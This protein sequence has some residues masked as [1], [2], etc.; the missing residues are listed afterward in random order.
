MPKINRMTPRDCRFYGRHRGFHTAVGTVRVCAVNCILWSNLGNCN[1]NPL[2][3]AA[4]ITINLL[5]LLR[6]VHGYCSNSNHCHRRNYP[7]LHTHFA[8]GWLLVLLL[9]WLGLRA[10]ARTRWRRAVSFVNVFLLWPRCRLTRTWLAEH[11]RFA[12]AAV[13]YWLAFGQLVG[14]EVTKPELESEAD[15][16]CGAV[17]QLLI[18]KLWNCQHFY[19]YYNYVIYKRKTKENN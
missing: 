5:C 15:K 17:G 19:F 9:C 1:Y 6:P 16:L 13:T 10:R 14:A 4:L 3:P 11:V 18:K 12:A 7:L 8:F 2:W